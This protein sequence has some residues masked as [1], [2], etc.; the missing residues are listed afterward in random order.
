MQYQV[1]LYHELIRCGLNIEVGYYHLGSAQQATLDK[2]FG[3]QF[4][5]DVDLLDGYPFRVFSQKRAAYQL[6]EQLKIA[7][8]LLVWALRKPEAPL[9]LMGWF[10]EII[11]LVWLLR[12]IRRAPVLVFGDNTPESYAAAP[13]PKWRTALLR[14]LLRHTPAVLYVG[15]RNLAFWLNLGVPTSR[16]YHTPHSV[17][18]AF[19]A[20]EAEKS[21]AQRRALCLAYG[22]D[23]D[24]PT[25]LFC[26]K[27][28]PIKRPLQLL[29]AFLAAGL[30]DKAQ[31]IYVGDGELRQALTDRI[32]AEGCQNVHLLGFFN[33]TQIPLAY[34]LGQMLCLVS[35]SETWGLVVNEAM[36]CGLPV[37]VTETVGCQPDL[38]QPETGWVVKGNDVTTLP[39]ALTSALE[40]QTDWPALGRAGYDRVQYYSFTT[41]A[42]GIQSALAAI[43]EHHE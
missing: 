38:V 4:K 36:A 41:M 42:Q 7:P 9:L 33:Q 29:E 39:Q 25:F 23:P 20:S 30:R 26:G 12:I 32:R 24:L 31:L 40:R 5:W 16:L 37:M 6:S 35:E 34:V 27:L 13:R 10:A 17:D 28:I 3:L 1:P 19:F 11:W 22:L 15:Q 8:R 43:H 21:R 14:G 2:E 18:N